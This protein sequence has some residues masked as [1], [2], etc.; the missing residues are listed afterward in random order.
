MRGRIAELE[1]IAETQSNIPK[2][3]KTRQ[4]HVRALEDRIEVQE[5][6][7]ENAPNPQQAVLI[8]RVAKVAV[9]HLYSDIKPNQADF[10]TE[11]TF[12]YIPCP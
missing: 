3:V 2:T 12:S 6:D 9:A 4:E 7:M 10:P 11:E 5:S 1:A 8:R